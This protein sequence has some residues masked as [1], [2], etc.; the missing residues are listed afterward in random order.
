MPK[1]SEIQPSSSWIKRLV[2]KSSLAQD[3]GFDPSK[4]SQNFLPR[5]TDRFDLE[6]RCLS[7]PV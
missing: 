4:N 1:E 3:L 7:V 6:F 2:F 5:T